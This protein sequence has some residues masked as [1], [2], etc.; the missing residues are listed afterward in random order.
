MI[1]RNTDA[2]LALKAAMASLDFTA[3]NAEL[4]RLDAEAAN[5]NS[6]AA[7]AEAEADRLGREIR[8]WRGPDVDAIADAMI[9]GTD[10]SEAALAAPSREALVEQRQT[11]QSTAANLRERVSR[12]WRE[13]EDVAR[14]QCAAI[15][16]AMGPFLAATIAEQRRA[17]QAIL[18]CDAVLQAVSAMTGMRV[19]GEWPS[20]IAREALTKSNGL[21]GPASRLP[22]P[23]DVQDALA[24]LPD[25]AK[26]LRTPCPAEVANF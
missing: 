9:A 20:R 7:E 10:A 22:V 24:G 11:L 3:S 18:D 1:G 2:A 25:R 5:L 15:L 12:A 21:I 8:D 16:D 4:A 14:G 19:D 23:R 13:R 6:K 26:G 17:A